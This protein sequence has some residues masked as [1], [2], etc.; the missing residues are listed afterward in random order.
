MIAKL[1]NLAISLSRLFLCSSIIGS[2]ANQ[3]TNEK[4]FNKKEMLPGTEDLQKLQKYLD[5]EIVFVSCVLAPGVIL[6]MDFSVIF[7]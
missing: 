7:K 1:C 3:T 6:L 2:L 5:N 4:R